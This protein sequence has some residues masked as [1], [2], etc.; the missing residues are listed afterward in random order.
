LGA[1][2]WASLLLQVL[3]GIGAV[4]LLLAIAEGLNLGLAI[5][6][7]TRP[8]TSSP[9]SAAGE[10]KGAAAGVTGVENESGAGTA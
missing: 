9:N 3:Y 10:A 4:A 5:E 1:A 2:G 6:A 7:N 8:G